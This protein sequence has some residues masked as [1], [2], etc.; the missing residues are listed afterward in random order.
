MLPKCRCRRHHCT[1]PLRWSGAESNEIS[2]GPWA[3]QMCIRLQLKL[4]ELQI[5]RETEWLMD[6]THRE[7]VIPKV[8]NTGS[9]HGR[10]LDQTIFLIECSE[11]VQTSWQMFFNISLSSAIIPTCFKDTTIVPMPK[12]SSAFCLNDYRPPTLTSI[13]MKCFKRLVMRHIKTLRTPHWAPC[14]S[15]IIPTAQQT[16]PSPPPATWPS[17][18][19]T[20]KTHPF[21]CCL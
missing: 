9:T 19:W 11:D 3:L 6:R 15:H 4:D 16:T 5:I 10:L 21:E 2:G 12:K 20:K 13:I 8:H 7:V 18:T 1:A 17:P 14:S